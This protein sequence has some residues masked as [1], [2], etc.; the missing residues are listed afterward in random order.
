MGDDVE[1]VGRLSDDE[2]KAV[3]WLLN[4]DVT[5]KDFKD[6]PDLYPI[7]HQA[8][9]EALGK[10]PITKDNPLVNNLREEIA[11]NLGLINT[12]LSRLASKPIFGQ[13]T[14]KVVLSKLSHE[15]NS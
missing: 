7:E 8:L 5:R 9:S 6:K 3:L 11:K 4:S 15:G 1:S 2:H 10:T 14:G 12:A 13:Y